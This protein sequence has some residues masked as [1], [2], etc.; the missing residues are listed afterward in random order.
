VPGLNVAI[1]DA[2]LPY[3]PTSGKRL[4]TLNLMLRLAGR[5]RLTYLVR[6][7]ARSDEAR[8]AL[9]YLADHGVEPVLIDHPVPPKRGPAFYARLAVNLLS[10]LPYSVSS[11]QSERVR[12]ALRDHAAA[13]PVDLWQ[14]EWAPYVPM[15]PPGAAPLVVAAPNVESLIWQR[16]YETESQPLK[17]WYVRQQWR[18]FERFE[19]RV[20]GAAAAVVAVSPEDA[21]LAR[22]RF[23]AAWAPVVDNGVDVAHFE[24]APV[25]RQPRQVLFLGSLDWRPNLDGARLLLERVFPALR[26]EEPEARLLLVGRNPPPWLA[27]QVAQV[28]GA[29]LHANVADV[30]PYLGR[31]A[32]LAVPLRIGGGSRLKILEALACGLPVVSTRVGAEGLCLREGEHLT[33]VEGID[34]LAAALLRCLR[35]PGPAREMAER[36]RQVVRERYDWGPL[37]DKLERVWE[38]CAGGTFRGG[39]RDGAVAGA[40]P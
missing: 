20:F 3:P 9:A 15:R 8:Q 5:H 38:E 1:V 27:A 32:V 35:D 37:A 40:A 39:S 18:K 13:R 14:F 33:L 24:Q 19:R 21:A 7:D 22:R 25:D 29:E 11:H 10:P 34:D 12:Q 28:P 23:G 6:G 31:S 30:C 17:R 16:Y 26:A 2:D 36:G 4:R